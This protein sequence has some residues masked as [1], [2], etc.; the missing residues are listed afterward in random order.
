MKIRIGLQYKLIIYT[1]V[2]III[3]ASVFSYYLIERQRTLLLA[4][5]EERGQTVA[6]GIASNCQFSILAEDISSLKGFVEGAMTEKDVTKV[7]IIT[8]DGRILAHSLE[9]K[10]G[11]IVESSVEENGLAGK[12][13]QYIG[14]STIIISI[15]VVSKIAQTAPAEEMGGFEAM[16][17]FGEEEPEE[18]LSATE[19]TQEDIGIIQVTMSTVRIG[20]E[21]QEIKRNIFLVTILIALLGIGAIIIMSHRMLSPLKQIITKMQRIC[22]GESQDPVKIKTHDEIGDFATAF[23]QMV[24]YLGETTGHA[25]SISQ[26]DL[27][28]EI[29]PRSDKDELGE[30]FKEMVTY[31][32]DMAKIAQLVAQGNLTAEVKPRSTNDVFG[33]ALSTMIMGLKD[34]ISQIQDSSGQIHSRANEMASL[35]TA[36]SETVSQMASNVNQISSSITKISSATQ[37]VAS[38]AQRTSALA[39][40]GDET[41][42]IVIDKVSHSKESAF[43]TVE[44][45]NNLGKCSMQIGDIINY[46]T[47][48]ADQTNLLSLNATIEAARAGEAGR[49]FAVV[50]G[51]VRKLAEGSAHSAGEIAQLIR[52]VQVET[53]RVVT[54]VE[55][56]A[57]EVGE[58][59]N[60]SHEAGKSF[61]DITKAAKDIASQV[62]GIAASFEETTANAEEASA[63]TEEQVATFEEI[64][65][66]IENLKKI[67]ENLRDS[68][69][70]FKL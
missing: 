26:G 35:S 53:T 22:R 1:A 16:M 59:T 14:E 40:A 4:A 70:K 7:A 21:L 39:Q 43:Q 17:G 51:E 66:S 44:L 19:F 49:G 48:V 6:H 2:L 55:T 32:R 15:P 65:A 11:S 58:S 57:T 13:I 38:V 45:I 20:G 30:A 68:S 12:M 18:E 27:N 67:A 69:A 52:E 31:L 5:L 41:I 47:K 37:A 64:S 23:N 28:V 54:A 36:S 33:N 8:K 61:K 9:D 56:V 62:E 24:G 29:H 60:V 25:L 42:S 3:M 50:A 46:I 63:S 34:L 10:A